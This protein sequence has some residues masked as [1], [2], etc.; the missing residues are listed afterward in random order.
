MITT[1]RKLIGA[2]LAAAV[3][4]FMAGPSVAQDKEKITIGWT[5]WDDAVFITNLTKKILEDRMSIDVETSMAA[6]GIQYE[7][8]SNGD[9]DLMMM[10]WLPDT[11]KDYWAK[12]REKAVTLGILYTNAVLGWAVPDYVDPQIQSI[13]DLKD[14]AELFDGKI[15]GI[16]PG[17]GLMRL[18]A[19]AIKDYDLDNFELVSASDAAMTAA[20]ARAIRREEPIVVTTWKPHWMFG[21]W[22]LRMLKD[23]KHTLGK[24]QHVDAK[25]RAGFFTDHPEVAAVIARINLPIED[26]ETYMFKASET[27]VDEAVDAFIAENPDR[28]HYWV[29][30]EIK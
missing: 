5:A 30:G 15:Q 27:S 8:I 26:V 10:S 24:Q 1:R 16:D 19:D 20:L 29:T 23:P 22:K 21:R 17:A 3:L 13:E 7:G 9:L 6:I 12:A 2:V 28:V 4:V 11:H 14:H 18:S 25:A